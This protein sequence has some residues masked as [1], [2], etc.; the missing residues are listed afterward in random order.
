MPT[1]IKQC[2]LKRNQNTGANPILDTVSRKKWGTRCTGALHWDYPQQPASA[3]PRKG[4][5]TCLIK[6]GLFACTGT[7]S[8]HPPVNQ[9]GTS[10]SLI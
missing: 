8:T 1:H 5:E 2:L 3:F 4:G 10:W 7:W 9:K 6:P